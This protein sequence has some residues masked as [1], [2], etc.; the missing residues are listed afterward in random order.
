VYELLYATGSRAHLASLDAPHTEYV[1]GPAA[2]FA[3]AL[4]G[5]LFNLVPGLSRAILSASSSADMH[6]RTFIPATSRRIFNVLAFPTTNHCIN[7]S[8]CVEAS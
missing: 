4:A 1:A 6:G 7:L 5:M 2:V 8:G 3:D